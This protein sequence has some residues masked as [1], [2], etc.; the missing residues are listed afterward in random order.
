M[1]KLNRNELEINDDF[2]FNGKKIVKG[3]GSLRIDWL[4]D[5][6]LVKVANDESGWLTLLKDPDDG[7]F[8]I[9]DYPDSSTHGGGMRCL[10][11]IDTNEIAE[12]FKI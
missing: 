9:L 2:Y 8:W 10:R 12:K 6:H 7:R 5:N 4:L 11:N 3:E 1:K